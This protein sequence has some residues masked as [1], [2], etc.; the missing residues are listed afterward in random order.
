MRFV[1]RP[2]VWSR[3]LRALA[4]ITA[5]IALVTTPAFADPSKPWKEVYDLI[6]TNLQSG[7]E[8]D[9]SQTA[10]EQWI[11]KYPN[12]VLWET[13]SP[14][15]T[16]A[17]IDGP[18][19]TSRIFESRYVSLRVQRVDNSLPATLREAWT[20]VASTNAVLGAV[21][22]LRFAGGTD[23]EA[24]LA[25]AQLFLV[26]EAPRFQVGGVDVKLPANT[27][28]AI[29]PRG[30][31]MV[32]VNSSTRGAAEALAAVLKEQRGA[33]LLGS[34]SA[35]AVGVYQPFTLS[36][37]DRLKLLTGEIKA[38]NTTFPAGT[39]LEPDLPVKVIEAEELALW[40]D[41]YAKPL[42]NPAPRKT[43]AHA[44]QTPKLNEATLVRRQKEERDNP[45]EDLLDEPKTTVVEKVRPPE[46]RDPVLARALDIVEALQ[47]LGLAKAKQE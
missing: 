22:D 47:V 14:A 41:P 44:A 37:G 16:E 35:G 17:K 18:A 27:G 45:A 12:R 32:L 21:L 13:N 24:S 10:V 19:A 31:L 28:A 29:Y 33:V 1:L 15:K 7:V 3:P 30:P 26:G 39:R 42:G 25:T 46:L 23:Y 20:G 34:A 40:K 8:N 5:G 36:N 4:C 2:S 11:A 9:L 43:K 38:G 6:R